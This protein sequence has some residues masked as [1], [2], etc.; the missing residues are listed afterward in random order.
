MTLADFEDVQFFNSDRITI[1]SKE[2]CGSNVLFRLV[3]EETDVYMLAS[4]VTAL[5]TVYEALET[6]IGSEIT[7]NE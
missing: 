7:G 3:I 1:A 2:A 6:S 5:E 4:K